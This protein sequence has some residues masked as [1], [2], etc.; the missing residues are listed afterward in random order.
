M[1]MPAF[2]P[3]TTTDGLKIANRRDAPALTDRH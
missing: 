1:L 2:Y 3:S